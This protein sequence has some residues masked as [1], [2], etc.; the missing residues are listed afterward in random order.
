MYGNGIQLPWLG[1]G[2]E[3]WTRSVSW[4]RA[5]C[6]EGDLTRFDCNGI[7]GKA[8]L[9]KRTCPQDRRDQPIQSAADGAIAR[10][11]DTTRSI[12]GCKRQSGVQSQ[13]RSGMV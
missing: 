7:D 11:I 12:G 5:E 9:A 1:T 13:L 8:M 6:A 4:A 3:P 10:C 2:G